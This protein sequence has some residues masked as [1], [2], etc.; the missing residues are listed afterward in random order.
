SLTLVLGNIDPNTGKPIPDPAN[1]GG[2]LLASAYGRGD[3][4]IRLNNPPMPRITGITTTS[5][6]APISGIIVSFNEP[7][8]PNTFTL[9]DINSFSGPNGSLMSQLVQLSNP[10]ATDKSLLRYEIDFNPQR[11]VGTYTINIGPNISDFA[12]FL[13]DQNN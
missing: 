7:V 2:Y 6:S 3:F 4:A 13:M 5:S 1:P 9:G 8:D 12:G 11:T 10:R